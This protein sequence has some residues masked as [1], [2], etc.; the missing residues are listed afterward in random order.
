MQLQLQYLFFAVDSVLLASSEMGYQHA[1]AEIA[2]TTVRDA[3][4]LTREKRM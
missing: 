1:L 4:I 3:Y 2:I